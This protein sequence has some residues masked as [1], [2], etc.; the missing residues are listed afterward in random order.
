MPRFVVFNNESGR[1]VR[2]GQASANDILLQAQTGQTA[3]AL[4]QDAPSITDNHVYNF[5]N[6]SWSQIISDLDLKKRAKIGAI[7]D[8]C[9]GAITSNYNSEATGLWREYPTKLIDQN[10]MEQ[11]AIVGGLLM[12]KSGGEWGLVHH[13]A[14][15][16]VNVL[17]DFR[18]H[19]DAARQLLAERRAAVMAADTPEQIDAIIFL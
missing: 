19:C 15:Q 1:A 14:E 2:W 17:A 8:Q 18:G 11:V 12:T 3:L 6:G 9:A 16:G 4:F 7:T 5:A 13:T 10:N